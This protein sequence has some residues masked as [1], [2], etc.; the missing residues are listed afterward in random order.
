LTFLLEI[1][2]FR[3]ALGPNVTDEER[4]K[5]RLDKIF[6]EKTDRGVSGITPEKIAESKQ[7]WESDEN[8]IIKEENFRVYVI[9]TRQQ[10][11]RMG[12]Y[13]QE[14]L[15]ELLIHNIDNGVGRTRTVSPWCLVGRSVGQTVYYKNQEIISGVS[16]AYTGYR[17]ENALYYI[18]DESKD[19]FG[20]NGEYYIGVVLA[21]K[22]GRFQVASMYNGEYNI[23]PQ[24][25]FKIYPKLGGENLS[26]LT[27][28]EFDLEAE[29][30]D[31]EQPITIVDR[32]NETEGSPYAFWL[33]GPDEKSQYI[34]AGNYLK[35]PK[36]WE[37]MTDDLRNEYITTITE[38]NALA[39]V[40][41]DE[42]MR[43]IIKSGNVWRSRLD[44][45]LKQLEFSGVAYLAENFMKLEF[46]ADFTGKKNPNIKIYKSIRTGKNG[47]YNLNELN[48][49]E[50]DG[51]SYEPEFT[52]HVIPLPEGELEDFT[53]DKIYHIV[54]Y[55]SPNTRF[56]TLSDM[57]DNNNVVYIMSER[58]Y[59]ELREK[60]ES[61]DNSIDD[62]NDVDIAEQGY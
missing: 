20:P 14:K 31:T 61:G 49:L 18:I 24:D 33:Q 28:F 40:A 2:K 43:A 48:W 13:Y 51:K 5:L 45:K 52:K 15:R 27:Y 53:N 12:Y 6:N 8:L 11:V 41:T 26:K 36:S 59:Y 34:T 38:E 35:N 55:V 47:I 42:F 50:K 1:S 29:T 30:N 62:G 32:M 4:E 60:M 10:S 56:Y 58:K 54:E 44:Y 19:L 23:S 17:R 39:K 22:N 7:M 9:R 37:T 16:N 3:I 25:L 46:A 21:G 57:D